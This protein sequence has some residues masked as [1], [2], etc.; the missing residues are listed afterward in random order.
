MIEQIEEW[1][2]Q[3]NR[4]YKSSRQSCAKFQSQFN[5]FYY[6]K[7]LESAYFV[8]VNEIP[9]PDWPELR[10]EGLGDYIDMD[11]DGIT[12]DNTYYVMADKANDLCLN[13]HE[14]VHVIQW[15]ELTPKIFIK[16]YI[17]EL[18]D[19]SYEQSPLEEM[20]YY[21][22]GHFQKGGEKMDVEEYVRA[23]L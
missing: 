8:T 11:V 6:P 23:N 18:E 13:F 3:T 7:F 21:L 1:I 5:G 4:S 15:R 22:E 2:R 17:Q 10:E 12:Y 16:R 20:D 9:K 14:L 19:F